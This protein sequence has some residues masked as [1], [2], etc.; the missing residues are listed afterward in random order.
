MCMCDGILYVTC[1]RYH[2]I[3]ITSHLT[4]AIPLQQY[5]TFGIKRK[6]G[7]ERSG[8][9]LSL[10][11]HVTGNSP[12]ILYQKASPSHIKPVF[13]PLQLLNVSYLSQG[14]L[15]QYILLEY[16][17]VVQLALH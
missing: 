12:A 6:A 1:F 16:T 8:A 10:T 4:E 2:C 3:H 14:I 5:W 7:L 9:I 17:A 13:S 15:P 11:L